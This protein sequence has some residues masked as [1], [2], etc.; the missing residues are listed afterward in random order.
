[1]S[2]YNLPKG[3]SA[4]QVLFK[5][6]A[7]LDNPIIFMK[8][9]MSKF[10]DTY[11]ATIGLNQKIIITQDPNFISYI[12]KENHKNYKK[13]K[14]LSENAVELFG[15]GLLFSNG[16]YWLKQRRLIQP[17]FHKEKLK[18]LYEI[19][20]NSIH[21]SINKF[22]IG[23]D[24]DIFPLV[25]KISFTILIKS[26]FDIN[27]PETTMELLGNT[28]SELQ[29]FFIKDVNKPF[30]K[31][32]YPFTGEKKKALAKAKVVRTI[33][34]D[35]IKERKTSKIQF[36]DLLDMLLNSKY[37]DTGL[38]MEEEQ[39][40]DELII[41]IFAGHESTANTIS[42]LFYLIATDKE[43]QQKIAAETKET[44]ILE[45]LNN[46]YLKAVMYE[47]MR[48]YPA[49]WMTGRETI[50]NDNFKGLSFPKNTII[51]PFFY[52]LH[53]NKTNWE[54]ADKFYP[55]RF[56]NDPSLAKSKNFFPFGAGPRMCIGNNFAI[57]EIAF[58]LHAFFAKFTI[59]PTTQIPQMKSLITL[60]PDKVVLNIARL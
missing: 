25:H 15:N 32:I 51:V 35:I 1:M 34:K 49:A 58:F 16:M 29:T 21:V 12:L 2:K 36:N 24:I 43:S 8:N 22:P 27:V 44:T 5:T 56:L 30:E 50:E 48:L 9:S 42:W 55:Q 37:E 38:E 18:G 19:V 60:K 26:L 45:S 39:V 3:Y 10:G 17:G 40:I 57:A 7:F 23:N 46:E 28:F 52:G 53:R 47:G 4:F 33:F 54:D 59:T 11:S 14:F 20:I 41:L 31:I 6:K 13:S